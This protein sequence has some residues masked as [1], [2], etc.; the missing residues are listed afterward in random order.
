MAD[1]MTG[2][3]TM[4]DASG[5]L[6]HQEQG[7]GMKWMAIRDMLQLIRDAIAKANPGM[8]SK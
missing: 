2:L 3:N 1:F 7:H 5:Q 4:T 6:I 8:S